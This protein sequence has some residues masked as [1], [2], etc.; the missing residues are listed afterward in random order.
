MEENTVLAFD[1]VCYHYKDGSRQVNILKD[2]SY[3]FEKGK[4]YAIV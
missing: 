2:A 4:T 1:N 3:E